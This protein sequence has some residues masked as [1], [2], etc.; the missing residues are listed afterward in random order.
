MSFVCTQ[1]QSNTP[2]YPAVIVGLPLLIVTKEG[3]GEYRQRKKYILVNYTVPV[4]WLYQS[5]FSEEVLANHESLVTTFNHQRIVNVLRCRSASANIWVPPR[6][7]GAAG[8]L[9]ASPAMV[10]ANSHWVQMQR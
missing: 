5:L 4:G 2:R 3:Q 9:T 1:S 8:S 10:G 7:S 6:T